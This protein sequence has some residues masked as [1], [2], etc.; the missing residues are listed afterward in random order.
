MEGDKIEKALHELRRIGLSNGGSLGYHAGWCDAVAD[1]LEEAIR[2]L[3]AENDRLREANA[4]FAL[5]HLFGVVPSYDCWDDLDRQTINELRQ[6]ATS[7]C[8]KQRHIEA[9]GFVC[10][11]IGEF[12]KEQTVCNEGCQHYEPTLVQKALSLILRQQT[13]IIALRE[14]N[15][16]GD[17]ERK[18]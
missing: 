10:E 4:G 5:A 15:A 2:D 14:V 1:V 17:K 18:E 3:R 13:E 6:S 11:E 7:R 9:C 8:A 16:R 12:V